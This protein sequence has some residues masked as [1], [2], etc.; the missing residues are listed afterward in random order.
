MKPIIGFRN[1]RLAVRLFWTV[2]IGVGAL[3][4]IMPFLFMLSTAFKT[5]ADFHVR[6]IKWIPEYWYPDNFK[7]VL[8]NENS[9]LR[10]YM[11]SIKIT[12]ICV[13][14]A[15]FTSI[16]AA[17]SFSKIEFKG[18]EFL[19]L[20]MIS[21]MMI[22]AQLTYIPKFSMF[23]S[24]GLTNTHLS[25]ILPGLYAITGCFLIKQFFDQ[26]PGE[27]KEAARIDGAG[28]FTIC[29]KI[30]VPMSKPALATFIITTFTHFWN[31]YDT[32]LIFLRN[33]DLFT[34]PL[35]IVSFSD[36]IG[37]LYHYTMAFSI[38]ALIPIFIVFVICQNYF[39]QGLTAG[40]VKM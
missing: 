33:K 2:I 21:T 16:M 29:W 36:D 40:A 27:M 34:V 20:L 10:M 37:Q 30:M 5:P 1:G 11:N 35:G 4:M 23:S 26:I 6:P 7:F 32:P 15:G 25:I 38:L 22:P 8:T 19:F 14:G 31:D 13:L 39:V 24:L 18:R 28:E 12:T 9:I 3:F 17:Y